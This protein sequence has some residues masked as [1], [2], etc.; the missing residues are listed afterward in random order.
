MRV[1]F[2]ASLGG[3]LWTHVGYP[4]AAALLARIRTRDVHKAD[5]T[6]SVNE[7]TSETL[8]AVTTTSMEVCAPTR[9]RLKTSRPN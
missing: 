8:V 4:L 7:T 1:L 9:M 3:I 5:V 2:W 6:P